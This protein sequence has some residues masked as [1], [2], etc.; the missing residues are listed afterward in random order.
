MIT[1]ALRAVV[2]RLHT[3]W[4]LIMINYMSPRLAFYDE[5]LIRM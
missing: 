4:K 3:E 1:V 2:A 5:S